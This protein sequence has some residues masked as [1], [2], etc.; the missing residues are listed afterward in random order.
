MFARETW[1]QSVSWMGFWAVV[2]TCQGISAHNWPAHKSD[3]VPKRWK[4][5]GWLSGPLR[6]RTTQYFACYDTEFAQRAAT[7]GAAAMMRN[8]DVRHNLHFLVRRELLVIL[9]SQSFCST[10]TEIPV[11]KGN[12]EMTCL[13]S[14][15]WAERPLWSESYNR[16]AVLPH[17]W[18]LHRF[19]LLQPFPVTAHLC[20]R[21]QLHLPQFPQLPFPTPPCRG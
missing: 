18:G 20:V 1:A 16:C 4:C 9:V 19:P 2:G 12:G 15:S 6:T 11:L 17:I 13:A 10:I 14:R 3:S 21:A 8:A 5:F 7:W